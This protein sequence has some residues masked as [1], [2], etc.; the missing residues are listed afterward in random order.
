MDMSLLKAGLVILVLLTYTSCSHKTPESQGT[1]NLKSSTATLEQRAKEQQIYKRS[2]VK[3][4]WW[5]ADTAAPTASYWIK[6]STVY[7]PD[8][9]GDPTFR[10]DL[11]GD[12]LVI[13]QDGLAWHWIIQKA[14][15]DTLILHRPGSDMLDTLVR[16]GF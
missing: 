13:H 7:Y 11:R 3:G 15:D 9:D 4:I 6:D 12:T 1:S 16:R 5:P 10:Y 8:E 2:D 14:I